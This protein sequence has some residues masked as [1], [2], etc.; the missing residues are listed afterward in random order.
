MFFEY[1]CNIENVSQTILKTEFAGSFIISMPPDLTQEELRQAL[2]AREELRQGGAGILRETADGTVEAARDKLLLLGLT[3][4]QVAEIERSGDVKD[5]LTIYSPIDG[6][7]VEKMAE[8]GAYVQTGDPIYR[9]A[10]LGHVWVLIDAYESDLVWL[11]F[12]QQVTFTA[13][14]WPGHEFTGRIS[15]IDP[16]LDSRSRTAKVRVNLDNEDLLLKPGMFVRAIVYP[17]IAA[18]GRVMAADLEGKWISPMHPEVVKDG[19]GQCDVCG[20]DLVPAEEMGYS[21]EDEGAAPPLVIPASANRAPRFSRRS[22][23]LP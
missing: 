6:V 17:E 10:D 11:R 5:H 3:E 13:E 14:A 7:V 22:F 1:N 2:R 8:Q 23:R 12:G 15:F 16:V 19:P 4:S 21:V 18:G 20:M 9:L